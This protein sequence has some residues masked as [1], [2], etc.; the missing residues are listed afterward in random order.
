LRNILVEVL[1][2]QYP[3]C[4]IRPP[5]LP[6]TKRQGKRAAGTHWAGINRF[7]VVGANIIRKP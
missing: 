6:L 2:D 3:I 4:I 1:P 7:G 5:F